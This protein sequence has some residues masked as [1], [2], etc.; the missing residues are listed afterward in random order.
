MTLSNAIVGRREIDAIEL[1]IFADLLTRISRFRS[2][3]NDAYG[4]MSGFALDDQRKLY[5]SLGLRRMLAFDERKATVDRQRFNRPS[6]RNRV[7]IATLAD[8]AAD[9]PRIFVEEG[10]ED[11]AN[12]ILWV[13]ADTSE[14]VG[15]EVRHF[16]QLVG[17][18]GVGGIARITLSIDYDRWAG[19]TH[20]GTG[21][22]TV[23][24][25]GEEARGRVGDY[26]SEFLEVGDYADP[27]DAASLYRCISKAFGFGAATAVGLS[28]G[29]TFEPL[30]VIRYGPGPIDLTITGIVIDTA[31]RPIV[32]GHIEEGNWPF[33]SK[34]WADIKDLRLPDLTFR[35]R[36]ELEASAGDRLTA[37]KRLHFDLDVASG[38]NGVFDSFARYHRHL[39]NMVAV[40]I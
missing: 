25:R 15:E 22:R 38:E 32:R 35:E 1:T 5:R 28:S 7:R 26:L 20:A 21:R 12:Y 24:E 33:A 30:S 36:F 39:P 9:W 6:I 10:L 13:R 27:L 29:R 16:Q 11:A 23:T 2:L 4:A 8:F 37:K 31:D 17:S 40:D 14:H 18:L 3:T 19:P 34:T